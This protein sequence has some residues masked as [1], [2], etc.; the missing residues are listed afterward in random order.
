MVFSHAG[1]GRNHPNSMYELG[2]GGLALL[3]ILGWVG[4]RPRPR[5]AVAG[6]FL[7]VYAA[8]RLLVE[9]VLTHDL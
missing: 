9:N 5:N 1:S 3:A 6:L 2:L 7:I 4:S 8:F